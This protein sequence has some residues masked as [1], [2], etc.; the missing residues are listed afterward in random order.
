[1]TGLEE[2]MSSTHKPLQIE[3]TLSLVHGVF[4][5]RNATQSAKCPGWDPVEA[6]HN[7]GVVSTSDL[8]TSQNDLVVVFSIA[9]ATP[10]QRKSWSIDKKVFT[11]FLSHWND[12][13]R[14]MSVQQT[15]LTRT[16]TSGQY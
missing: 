3:V 8:D 4:V 6:K 2:E 14:R 16:Q 13:S 12:D 7:L 10:S 9:Y 11:N 1:M 5:H 15:S